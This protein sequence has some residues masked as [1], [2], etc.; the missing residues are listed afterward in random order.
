[1][2]APGLVVSDTSLHIFSTSPLQALAA[3]RL[4]GGK[5]AS[6]QTMQ[7]L[8]CAQLCLLAAVVGT[9][10]MQALQ[11]GEEPLRKQA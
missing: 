11:H 2:T 9:V 10:L 6:K 1:M 7:L 3:S 8:S 5:Q 4:Q